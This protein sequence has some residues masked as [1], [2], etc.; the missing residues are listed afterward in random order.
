MASAASAHGGPTRRSARLSSVARSVGSQSIATATPG[1]SATPSRRRG[2]LAKVKA[3]QSTAY[4]ASG[5]LGAAEELTVPVT[6]FAQ[7]FQSQRVAAV[8]R[9]DE[10]L[11]SGARNGGAD[12]HSPTPNGETATPSLHGYESEEPPTDEEQDESGANTSKSFGMLREAGMLRALTP[13]GYPSRTGNS[14][15]GPVPPRQHVLQNQ[16]AA[17][18]APVGVAPRRPSLS[19]VR[20]LADDNRNGRNNS[21]KRYLLVAAVI[22]LSILTLFMFSR[23]PS[24]KDQIAYGLTNIAE[25]I[26]PSSSDSEHLRTIIHKQQISLQDVQNG[27]HKIR[28]DLPSRTIATKN[29]DGTWNINGEFWTAL[30][31]KLQTDGPSPDWDEFLKKNKEKVQKLFDQGTEWF[32]TDGGFILR[33]ELLATLE[34]SWDGLSADFDKKIT[35]LKQSLVKEAGQVAAKEAKKVTIEEGRLHSLALTTLLTNVE[36]STRKVNYFSTGLGT[37]IDSSITSATG[38]DNP[39]ILA[40]LYRRFMGVPNRAPPAAALVSWEEPGDCWCAAP[41]DS[42]KGKAQLGIQLSTPIY[43]TQLTVEHIP[44]AM[45]P[46]EDISSAPRDIEIWIKTSRQPIQRFGMGPADC[47]DGP[48]GWVCLGKARYDIHGANHVQTFLLDTQAQLPVDRVMVRVASNWGADH[49]CLYRVRLHGK[50]SQP[51]HEY[52]LH[53]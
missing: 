44:K 6:G 45:V 28:D 25:W 23:G 32:R 47:E 36:L 29:Q 24:P 30:V 9:V 1:A 13:P 52:R 40:R 4:G 37:Q 42:K 41:D 46:R 11:M 48:D 21:W 14:A 34:T 26:S 18:S 38:A 20:R 31:S 7:A 15:P 22:M 19:P 16:Q 2:P 49:T 53:D 8:S 33:D 43:P 10:P 27:L 51:A 5:R 3:R 12:R 39:A 35:E 50:D 17:S